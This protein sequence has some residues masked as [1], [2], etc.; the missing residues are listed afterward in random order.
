MLIVSMILLIITLLV[1]IVIMLAGV[2]H[3]PTGPTVTFMVVVIAFMP[4]L[5]VGIDRRN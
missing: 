1:L 4:L 5:T 2:Y 3:Y